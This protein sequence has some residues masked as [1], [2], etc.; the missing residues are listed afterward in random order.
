MI[1]LIENVF[2]YIP[3]RPPTSIFFKFLASSIV[4][5]NLPAVGTYR[6]EKQISPNLFS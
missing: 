6:S 3:E 2:Y 4:I 5:V 1:V